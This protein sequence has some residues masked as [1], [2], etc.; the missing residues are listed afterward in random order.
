MREIK[1]RAWSKCKE[2]MFYF[3]DFWVCSEYSSLAWSKDVKDLREYELH[4]GESGL[5]SNDEEDFELMQ[6]TGLK[7][8]NGKEI[9]EE[10]IVTT[11]ES[12]NTEVKYS[13]EDGGFTPFAQ[14]FF[15]SD[16]VYSWNPGGCKVV[17]N[18]YENPELL[19]KK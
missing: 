6:F 16:Y 19:K 12:K 2:L 14:G 9:W 15:P 8:K 1:F 17:G 10:D 7:D 5:P 13:I 18:I 4:A 11:K 3:P